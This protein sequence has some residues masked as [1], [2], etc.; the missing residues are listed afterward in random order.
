MR[1]RTDQ[2]QVTWSTAP[3][4]ATPRMMA[5]ILATF[6][7]AAGIAGLFAV[8]GPDAGAQGRW[9]IFT[10]ALVAL[11][12]GA[13]AFRW[14]GHWPRHVFHWP[15]AS[16]AALVAFAVTVS[17]DAAT[18][19]AAA[20]IMAFIA[21]DAFFF[22]SLRLAWL[23]MAFGLTAVT[24][25]LLTQ[26]DVPASI[27][28]ALDAV[29]VALGTVVRGLVIRA[30]SASRDPLTGLA[31]RRGFDDALHELRTAAART[32]EPLSAALL[33]LDHFKQ[34]NDTAG[35]EAGDRVLCRIADVWRRELPGSAVLARHGGDEFALLLPGLAGADALALVRRISAQHPEIG[36]SCGVAE[37]RPGQGAAE[38][39][40]RADRALYDAKAAGRGRC[41][42]EGGAGS[43]LAR[44]L[45]GALA[46]GD[47][48]VHYQ[49]IVDLQDGAVV[50]VEALA[51][52][53]HPE[54]GPLPP[55]EFVAVAEQS[56]L[57]H[58]LG[59]HVLRTA[60][61]ELVDVRTPAGQPVTLGVNVSGREL[62]DP[63]CALR[64]QHV[65]ADTGFPV[66]HLVL[67]VTEGLLEGESPTAVATL[68]AL[69]TAGIKVSI[70]DFGTGYSSLSRLDTLPADVLKLDR[71]FIATVHSSPRRAQMLQTLVEMCLGLGLDVVAEGVETAE[72][73][74]AVRAMGCTFA[75]GWRYGRPVPLAELLTGLRAGA[76]AADREPAYRG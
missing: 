64:V 62:N 37:L 6:Y 43:A 54:H 60:C 58:A 72:Q 49:P 5:R 69:R 17:P 63:G 18:A 41:E 55:E 51:R 76:E 44:D 1:D 9:V 70:D 14:A 23:H 53:T 48:Q 33:D 74:A 68:H 29:I 40:R 67:E 2:H 45:A 25:A 13:V 36:V 32:G 46:A 38:L 10:V 31:N 39:M 19:M 27:A 73:E 28:L 20:S 8:F 75:Q 56:G 34:I 52:W 11:A 26:D 16:A 24:A 61:T 50:G 15:V 4:V 65:L 71:S 12:C 7:V 42:L 47:V 66:E 21:V 3:A 59:A 22:F 57:V 35:H 30:S